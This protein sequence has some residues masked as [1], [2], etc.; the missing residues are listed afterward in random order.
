M[1]V[2]FGMCVACVWTFCIIGISYVIGMG[3]LHDLCG[4][5]LRPHN[6]SMKIQ[7]A[8]EHHTVTALNFFHTHTHTYTPHKYAYN[9]H[10]IGWVHTHTYTQLCALRLVFLARTQHRSFIQRHVSGP[11]RRSHARGAALGLHA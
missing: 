5:M 9:T 7:R 11:S 4:C 6:H 3:F 10:I 2:I 8:R 1:I